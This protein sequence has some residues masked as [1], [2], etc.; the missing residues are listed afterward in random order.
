MQFV[1]LL[2]C[3]LAWVCLHMLLMLVCMCCGHTSLLTAGRSVLSWEL[4]SS[5][6]SFWAAIL[7]HGG[8]R[9]VFTGHHLLTLPRVY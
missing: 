5:Q 7:M 3:I 6:D 2:A 4:S 8:P 1:H 9:T